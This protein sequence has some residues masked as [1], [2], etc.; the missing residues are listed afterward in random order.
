MQFLF[1]HLIH[2]REELTAL[3]HIC[4]YVILT[5]CIYTHMS[6]WLL[7]WWCHASS[8]D[9]RGVSDV[10]GSLR[11]VISKWWCHL[12][13]LYF[14]CSHYYSYRNPLLELF[15]LFDTGILWQTPPRLMLTS[16]EYR[17]LL[18]PTSSYNQRFRKLDSVVNVRCEYTRITRDMFLLD[19]MLVLGTCFAYCRTLTML[20][21]NLGVAT[22]R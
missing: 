2:L 13:K 4:T 12:T 11:D 14:N 7:S 22:V 10:T 21:E 9:V 19:G 8:Y 17:V 16:A 5:L 15:N 20:R 18:S 1:W 6:F 3:C